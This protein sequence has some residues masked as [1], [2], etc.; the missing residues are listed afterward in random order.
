VGS[1]DTSS[2]LQRLEQLKSLLAARNH[3]TAAELANALNVSLRTLNRDLAVLRNAGTPI[4]SDRGRG[5]GLR[6][7]RQWSIG[8]V[9]L[10]YREAIDVLLSLAVAENLSSALFLEHVRSTRNKLA[11]TFAP[12]HRERIRLLRRRILIGEPASPE[13]MTSYDAKQRLRGN[14]INEAFFE[15][16]QLE[17]VYS[18]G[19][20]KRSTRQIEPQFLYLSWPVW[21]LLAWDRMREDVRTFRI[22]RIIKASKRTEGFALRTERPFM[23]AVEDTGE[24]L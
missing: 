4:E 22:D 5:G 2:R 8:R 12:A 13:V 1:R 6:L 7:H 20:G 21:Y 15:M 19:R 9:H 18:D 16:K 11:A 24:R 3:I 17:I 14:S 23:K 10:D